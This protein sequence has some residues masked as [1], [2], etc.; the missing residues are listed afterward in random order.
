AQW[1][2]TPFTRYAVDNLDI[3]DCVYGLFRPAY[4]AELRPG[5]P[6]EGWHDDP[7]WGRIS[8][9]RTLFPIHLPASVRS[10]LF[11]PFNLME[12][13]GDDQPPTTVMTHVRRSDGALVVRGTASD[14]AGVWRVTVN[15]REARPVTPN[16]AEWEATLDPP[17]DGRLTARA[18]D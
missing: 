15:G 16:F 2:F 18:V 7:D 1:A 8:L 11:G 12:F 17:T 4:D 5:G 10:P 9:R 3:A 6:W 13:V 14:N